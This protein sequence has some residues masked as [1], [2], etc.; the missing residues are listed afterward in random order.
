MKY[1]FVDNFRGFTK[2]VLPIKNVTFFVGENSSGKTSILGLLNI[3][4]GRP[5]WFSQKF[6]T[7]E[8]EFGNFEDIVSVNSPNKSYFRFGFI[9][10]GRTSKERKEPGFEGFLLSYKKEEGM[11]LI[12]RYTYADGAAQITVKFTDRNVLCKSEDMGEVSDDLEC[13]NRI[14]MNWVGEH[15]GRRGGYRRVKDFEDTYRRDLFLV[16]SF[17]E[18][19]LRKTTGRRSRG[20]FLPTPFEEMAWLAPIR[21]KPQRTYDKYDVGFSPEGEH[22]PYLI[23]KLLTGEK[24]AERFKQFV[25]KFGQA[26]G[27]F[28]SVF[29]KKFGH[30]ITA[31][32]EL[33]IV[34]NRN[35]LR[36]HNVGYGVSQ[37]LP[38]IVELFAREKETWF[39][40]QQPEIHLHPRAQIALGEVL[41][42]LAVTENKKFIVETHVDFIIDGFRLNYR[43]KDITRKPDAQ[44]VFFES[45]PGGNVLHPINVLEN[46]ELSDKQPPGYREFFIKEQMRILNL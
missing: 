44:V 10:I 13:V 25:Q 45:T 2:T 18:D 23:K 12:S 14:F 31:P 40:I 35:A 17:V 28:E 33:D 26:S 15:E 7:E 34:L 36:I 32:F 27:L 22:T 1:L 19:T 4:R 43:K 21:T 42:E 8:V 3:I 6:D 46:G 5:F 37:S 16:S 41:F 38:I 9:E 20:L 39:A 29:V 11:P 24:S 30:S